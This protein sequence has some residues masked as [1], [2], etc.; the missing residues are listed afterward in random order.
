LAA[1]F[2]LDARPAGAASDT[3]SQAT[4]YETLSIIPKVAG[5]SGKSFVE[6]R[7]FSPRPRTVVR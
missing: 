4:R 5:V 2:F 3:R 7:F 1:A 6:S